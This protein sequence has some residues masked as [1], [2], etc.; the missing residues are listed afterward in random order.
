MPDGL[1]L[2]SLRILAVDDEESNLLLLQRILERAGYTDVA[3]TTEPSRVVEMFA[4][5][6]PDLVMLDLHMP[7]MNGF[8]LM[9]RLA[10]LTAD[11]RAVP[12]LV[13]TADASDETKRRALAAGARDFLTKPL[14]R[15]E[16]LLR[17]NNL[18]QVK[19][20]QDRL[21]E[22]NARLEYE[23][24]ERTRDLDQ[25]R[26][27]MLHRLALAGEYRDDQTQEHAWRI[28]RIS[29]LLAI[30]LDIPDDE[31]ELVARAAPLHDL[32]KIGISDTILLKPGP[33]T[34]EEFAVVKT[35]TTIGAEIFA[36][37]RSPVLRLAE[38][39]SLTHHER[40]DGR[41]YTAG[42]SGNDIPLVGRIVSVADVFD[43]LTHERPYKEA[44]PVEQA[45][46]E[47]AG[48]A[49]RQ[50]DPE[51][52]EVFATLDHPTLLRSI[53]GWEPPAPAPATANPQPPQRN[54]RRSVLT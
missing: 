17:V 52:V 35:H 32:G 10:P 53:S 45:V 48:Q 43:A 3:V 11:G 23:V 28:G 36:G 44:W 29:G 41:G 1:D 33:L 9:K 16:L 31:V 51:I 7:G 18:L 46:A 21:R 20:L 54:G 26:L 40:W 50:F 2:R 34:E 49:G 39:I 13:L 42:L 27:E 15:V 38:R 4:E 30:G 24:A 8:E 37:S 47:I 22:H 12:I 19:R 6:P 25:A 5:T 14:D